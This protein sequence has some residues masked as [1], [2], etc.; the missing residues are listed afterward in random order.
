MT[1]GT[2]KS[3]RSTVLEHMLMYGSITSMQAFSDYKITRISAVIFDLKHKDNINILMSRE[4]IDVDGEQK[5]FGRYTL[6]KGPATPSSS[7]A[8]GV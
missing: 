1:I 2:S 7:I 8:I 6:A 5:S 3:Q 4:K